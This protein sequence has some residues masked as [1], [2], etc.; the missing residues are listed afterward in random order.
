MLG[1]IKTRVPE[2]RAMLR[3][4][5]QS[6]LRPGGS[7]AH[8]EQAAGRGRASGQAVPAA[9]QGPSGANPQRRPGANTGASR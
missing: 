6:W 1:L 4:I 2:W 7:V 3:W 9:D 8:W 5:V